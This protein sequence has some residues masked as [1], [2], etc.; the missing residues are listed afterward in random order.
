MKKGK[1]IQNKRHG[2]ALLFALGILSLLLILGLAFVSNALLARKVAFNNS[3][4]SQAKMLAQSAINRVAISLMLYQYQAEHQ[5]DLSKQFWPTEFTA[6]YSYDKVKTLNSDS[7]ETTNDQ[8][9]GDNSKLNY[10]NNDLDYKGSN[11]KAVWTYFYDSGDKSDTDRKIIGR[12]AYQVLPSTSSSRINLKSV[13]GGFVA[14]S[15]RV[16]WNDRIGKEIDE[17]YIDKTTILQGWSTINDGTYIPQTYDELYGPYDGNFDFNDT[18]ETGKK[19]RAWIERWFTEGTDPSVKEAYIYYK[20]NGD[21]TTYFHR[22]PLIS[23]MPLSGDS[24]TPDVWYDRFKSSISDTT[25]TPNAPSAIDALTHDSRPFNETDTRTPFNSGLPFLRRIADDE[26]TFATTGINGLSGLENRRRQIAA[27]FNDYCDA[28]YIPT[29]NISAKDWLTKEPDYTGNEKTPYIY[30]IGFSSQISHDSGTAGIAV[31]KTDRSFKFDLE[32]TPAVKLINIY[33]GISD[34]LSNFD[35]YH[36]LRGIELKGKITKVAY[37]NFTYRTEAGNPATNNTVSTPMEIDLATYGKVEFSKKWEKNETANDITEVN[38]SQSISF[39]AADFTDGYAF[40]TGTGAFFK[41]SYTSVTDDAGTPTPVIPELTLAMVKEKY[42]SAVELVSSESDIE[43]KEVELT[44]FSIQNGRMV[45]MADYKHLGGAT[46]ERIGLDYVKPQLTKKLEQ[47]GASITFD[48][49]KNSYKFLFGGMRGQDPRQN[50]NEDDWSVS[51][52]SIKGFDEATNKWAD[53]MDV[54]TSGT[55]DSY[56]GTVNRETEADPRGKSPNAD[57]ETVDDPA[58]GHLSTAY[59]RNAPMKS[60]WEIGVIHRGAAWETINLKH[61]GSPN[62]SSSDIT[63]MDMEPNHNAW[64]KSGTSYQAGDG[65]ILEQIKMTTGIRALGKVDLNMLPQHYSG[66]TSDDDDIAKALF[67]NLSLGQPISNFADVTSGNRIATVTDNP[68]KTKPSSDAPFVLRTEFINW[69]DAGNNFLKTGFNKLRYNDG[70]LPSFTTDAS[71]EEVI[72]KTIN[73]MT[74]GGSLPNT[75]KVLIVAQTI[76][77]LGDSA[78]IPITRIDKDGIGQTRPAKN[79]Q[80]DYEEVGSDPEDNIYYD[81]I[82][83]EVKMIVTIDRNPETGKM[84]VRK[85]D[86]ID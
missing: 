15:G 2:V 75:I 59:I 21:D 84:M 73:L 46:T 77:D 19:H 69:K 23:W 13:L 18:T 48:D 25:I 56:K 44:D 60:P 80:F 50:L 45:L 29:S 83:G 68:L 11:S 36:T 17:L 8:L 78:G 31:N 74:A 43:I 55:P 52:P 33:D 54:E 12:V 57:Q 30:E 10:L 35:F 67:L 9:T 70:A 72:G 61:A 40:K 39:S 71:Q 3:T 1:K 26:G 28:D 51:D 63:P 62:A 82:T 66:Y 20:R 64:T 16:P 65:G 58:N 7:G 32:I 38:S 14:N 42:P 37:N 34:D 81:E 79:G 24:Y 86:Y 5:T 49:T 47:T 6:I 53:V 41:T 22:F 85:I 76:R 27:N 4:R